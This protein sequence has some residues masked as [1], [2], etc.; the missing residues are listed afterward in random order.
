MNRKVKLA[1]FDVDG[2]LFDGNLGI[3]FVKDLVSDAIFTEDIGN[4][5]FFWYKKYKNGKVK[6]SVAVDKCYEFY[7]EGL[8][9]QS[10]AEIKIFAEST[11]QRVRE[12]TY[13]FVEDLLS[14][15]KG[16]N[17]KIILISGSPIEMVSQICKTYDVSSLDMIAGV[18]EVKYGKYTGKSIFYPGSSE[19]KLLALDKYINRN[20]LEIDFGH[21]VAMGDNERDLGILNKVG[22]PFAFNPN[23]VLKSTAKERGMTIVYENDVLKK[24]KSVIQEL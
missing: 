17:Y 8:M 2:T 18:S 23:D 21:S 24:I 12:K 14:Y 13:T 16:K 22:Y 5:I 6:K 10:S 20:D 1:I 7:T 4:N 19:Q 9:G 11:W 3:E 15:L